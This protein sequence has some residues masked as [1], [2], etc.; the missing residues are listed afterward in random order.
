MRKAVIDLGTNTFNLMIGQVIK[1]QFTMIYTEK[2]SVLLGM[3]GINDGIISNEAM[4]RAKKCLTRFK[5]KCQG[6]NVS[7]IEGIGTSALRSSK[8]SQDLIDFAKSQ[9]SIE[10]VVISGD[11]EAELIHS[12]VSWIHNFKEESIIMDIG[13]GST[14]FIHGFENKILR[15]TS[16][17]IGVSRIYQS[18]GKPDAFSKEQMAKIRGFLS[19]NKD[20]FFNDLQVPVLIGSS[21][22]FETIYKLIFSQKFPNE[23]R[24]IQLPLAEV[25]EMLEWLIY[26][27]LE[28][29]MNNKWISKMRKPMMPITAMQMKWAIE[30]FKIQEIYVSPYSLKEGAFASLRRD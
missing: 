26:S 23:N 7:I 17:K 27:T 5:A 16:L 28:E 20:D 2:E 30:E 22:S 29:R 24:L 4:D 21:G 15:K 10:I 3:N 1:N 9:L 6:K 14:E 25:L 13:G 18:F 12:G 19:D 11:R 8:N